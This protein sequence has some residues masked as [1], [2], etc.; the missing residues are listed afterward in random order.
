MNLC[1]RSPRALTQPDV[2]RWP[3]SK[4]GERRDSSILVASGRERGCWGDCSWI[5][6]EA[7]ALICE[8]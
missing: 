5:P 3:E 2:V 1:P 4:I 6:V 8:G 7:W